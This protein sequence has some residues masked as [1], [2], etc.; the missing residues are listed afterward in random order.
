MVA[1]GFSQNLGINFYETF[2]PVVCLETTRIVIV[3]AA[4]KKWK[5]FQLDVK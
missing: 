3:V 2:S 5:I 1:R 4:Q